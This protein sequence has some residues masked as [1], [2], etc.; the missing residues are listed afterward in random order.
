MFDYGYKFIR[1]PISVYFILIPIQHFIEDI[2]LLV[3]EGHSI[4]VKNLP[5][6]VTPDQLEIEFKRFGPIKQGGV[7]VRSNKV[8]PTHRTCVF[9]PVA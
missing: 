5:L 9:F 7:Q 1:Y 8:I 3:G 4:Y 2:L 6:S